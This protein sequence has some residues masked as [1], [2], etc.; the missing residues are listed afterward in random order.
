MFAI[1]YATTDVVKKYRAMEKEWVDK[2]KAKA[3]PYQY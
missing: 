1:L 2:A 3:I